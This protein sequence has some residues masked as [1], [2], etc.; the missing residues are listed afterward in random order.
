M[1][2]DLSIGYI[3]GFLF[4]PVKESPLCTLKLV[5][6]GNPGRPFGTMEIQLIPFMVEALIEAFHGA[7][8][9]G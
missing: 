3:E 7:P 1:R 6:G 8:K 9:A 5:T 2:V 4:E